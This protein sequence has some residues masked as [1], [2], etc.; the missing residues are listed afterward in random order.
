MTRRAGSGVETP[1]R[2]R[3]DQTMTPS[4]GERRLASG[5]TVQPVRFYPTVLL[6]HCDG[7]KSVLTGERFTTADDTGR[8]EA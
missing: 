2:Y 4:R 3:T 6:D 1:S 8:S 5:S 7:P